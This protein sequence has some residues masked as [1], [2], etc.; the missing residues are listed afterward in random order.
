MKCGEAKIDRR[1][2]VKRRLQKGVIVRCVISDTGGL[3]ELLKAGRLH[4]EASLYQLMSYE[5]R[6]PVCKSGAKRDEV[7]GQISSRLCLVLTEER[8]GGGGGKA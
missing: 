4:P 7:W 3:P 6:G 2:G 8:R 1:K 5:M